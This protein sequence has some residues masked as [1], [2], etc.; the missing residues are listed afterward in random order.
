MAERPT[1][2]P[3]TIPLAER[4]EV[5]EADAGTSGPAGPLTGK[6]A[7]IPVAAAWAVP[8][9]GHLLLGRRARAAVFATLVWGSFALGLAHDG[10]VALRDPKQPFLTTL[11]IVANLG[12]GPADVASRLGVYGAPVY[13]M[14]ARNASAIAVYRDRIRS[15]LSIYG[16]AYLW[17]AGLMNLLLLFD[18]WDLA[19]GR[20]A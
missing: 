10:S 7:W 8:G 2:D 20:K 18:V 15:P 12:V 13:A 9:L 4:P 19:R 17:T 16:T 14:N 11:Q 5:P 3:E 6:P 1:G